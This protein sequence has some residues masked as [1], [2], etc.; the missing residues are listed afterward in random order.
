MRRAAFWLALPVTL[1]GCSEWS[2]N[3]GND[4]ND[5][6]TVEDVDYTDAWS[7]IQCESAV[8]DDEEVGPSDL[9]EFE[10]GGFEPVVAWEAGKNM[11]MHAQPLVADLDRD[12]EPEVIAVFETEAFS[13]PTDAFG[14]VAEL[15]VLRSNGS[16]LWKDVDA[17][18]GSGSTPAIGDLDGDGWPEIV[19]V[20]Q[21]RS[22]SVWDCFDGDFRLVAWDREGNELWESGPGFTAD[23]FDQSTSATIADMDGDGV[24]EI[25]AGRVIFNFDGTVRGI[26]DHGHGSYGMTEL[27]GF[28]TVCEGSVSAVADLDLDGQMEVIVGDAMYDADGKDVWYS[29]SADDGMISVANLD[30]DPE[31]EFVAITGMN[32]LARDTNGDILWGPTPVGEDD[33]DGDGEPDGNILAPAAIQD[34]DGDGS[35]EIV[36]AGGSELVAFKANGERLWSISDLGQGHTIQDNSGATGATFFDFEGDGQ[37]EV[38]YIDELQL[39]AV[40][41]TTGELK[42]WSGNHKS[43]T[44]F[45]YPTVAD[46]DADGHADILVSHWL[47]GYGLTAYRDANN[48]WA[49]ARKVLNQHQ[50]SIMNV[51]DD[52]SIPSDTTPNF[53]YFNNW[54]SAVMSPPGPATQL[55]TDLEAEIVG[56]CDDD[57]DAG[58]FH[59]V[60]RVVNRSET[61]MTPGISVTLYGRVDGVLE[62]LQ[63][64]RTELSINPGTTGEPLEFDIPPADL[65]GVDRLVLAVDDTG[66]GGGWIYECSEENNR[67]TLDGPFC[68]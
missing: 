29:G 39:V 33:K 51:Y 66:N 42:F 30:D 55:I 6:D 28:G 68:E 50:Y 47:Y 13:P 38:V 45:D 58:A 19:A 65:E 64:L 14:T 52:L 26:G 11:H 22:H 12:G 62:A 17:R 1:V 24:P 3:H 36:T 61:T 46:I 48:S 8:V 59:L 5:T 63:T 41:G 7:D 16:T 32:I 67:D 25:I 9:C 60:G 37:V 57:C 54:H 49:P 10:I 23:N 34:I 27:P 40:D 4:T 2:L 15:H 53:T 44:L 20:R 18:I 31:G 43:N 35:P 56:S 21:V